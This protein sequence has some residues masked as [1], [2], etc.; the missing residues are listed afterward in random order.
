[1]PI[2]GVRPLPPL[3]D[4]PANLVNVGSW[5]VLLRFGREAAPLIKNECSLRYRAL[6]LLRLWDRRNEPCG[7]P[8][9]VDDSL[10]RLPLP[11]SSSQ[12]RCG[13]S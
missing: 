3:V 5:V 9:A 12:C 1:M 7:S 13:Y 10:R 2:G 8:A 4:L 11:A 6:L